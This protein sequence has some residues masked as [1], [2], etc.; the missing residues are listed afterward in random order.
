MECPLYAAAREASIAELSS[1]YGEMQRAWAPTVT[2]PEWHDLVLDPDGLHDM[3]L[4]RPPVVAADHAWADLLELTRGGSATRE[5]W[6]AW[7]HAVNR[8]LGRMKRRRRLYMT[9]PLGSVTGWRCAG[10]TGWA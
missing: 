6:T 2:M 10:P 4:G 7:L 1:A 9:E 3:L 8:M 5:S